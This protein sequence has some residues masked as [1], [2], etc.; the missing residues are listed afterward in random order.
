MLNF[1]VF[2]QC[3]AVALCLFAAFSAMSRAEAPARQ[4]ATVNY[5]CIPGS[6]RILISVMLN[7]KIPA[8]L[9]VDTGMPASAVSETIAKKLGLVPQPHLSASGKPS[10]LMG[11]QLNTVDVASLGIGTGKV[12]LIFGPYP[13]VVFSDK[14]TAAVTG[15]G[16]DGIIGADFL[17]WMAVRLD[18][19]QH[20]VTFW[21]P[22]GLTQSELVSDGFDHALVVPVTD[23]NKNALYWVQGQFQNGLSSDAEKMMVDTGSDG[24]IISQSVANAIRLIPD[25]TQRANLLSGSA[26]LFR[27][28]V[29]SARFGD[30]TLHDFPVYYYEKE[31]SANPI[32]LGMDVLSGYRVLLDYAHGSIYL[33]S[34]VPDHVNILS[35]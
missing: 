24:T 27:A 19:P 20:Q 9:M 32:S 7:D 2:S 25:T 4:Q 11:Q 10:M 3:L 35:K 33:K 8:T 28:K 29:P 26:M 31:D 14:E 12:Q 15:P 1:R 13:L 18:R 23:P 21:Y 17:R 34:T 16:V 22:G 6:Q 30:L 5:T